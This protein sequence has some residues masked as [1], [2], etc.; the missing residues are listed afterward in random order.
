VNAKD[1]LVESQETE[2]R[3]IHIKTW[4][5]ATKEYVI[6]SIKDNARGV[7]PSVLGRIF[8]PFVTTKDVGKGTGLGLSISYGIIKE[9][10]GNIHFESKPGEGTT[11]FVSIAKSKEAQVA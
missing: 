5:D 10:G 3:T 4:Y 11:F 8:D 7:D 1:A 6:F 2:D 9:H